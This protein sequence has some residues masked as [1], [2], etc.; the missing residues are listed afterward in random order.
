M[1]PRKIHANHAAQTKWE[2]ERVLK[3]RYPFYLRVRIN[4]GLKAQDIDTSFD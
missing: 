3:L 4:K 1:L 2:K